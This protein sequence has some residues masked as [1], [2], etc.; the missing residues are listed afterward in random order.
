M[1][2]LWLALV[3]LIG[4]CGL[5]ALKV[6]IAT[7]AKQDA[8]FS[9]DK[10]DADISQEAS[11]KAD[12]LDVNYIEEAPDK[13][14]VQTVAIVLKPAVSPNPREKITKIISRHWHEGYAKMTKHSKRNR[15]LASRTR[16][17]S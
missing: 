3:F 14:P 13:K 12:R 16:H 4:I 7:P 6:S 15:R 11:V 5:A 2:P 1:R 10:S 17:R 9:D 8:A